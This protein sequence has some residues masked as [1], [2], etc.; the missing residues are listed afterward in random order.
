[1][2][3]NASDDAYDISRLAYSMTGSVPDYKFKVKESANYDVT[4]DLGSMT[5]SVVKSDYQQKPVHHGAVADR[6]RPRFRP[7]AYIAR[8]EG[9]LALQLHAH[10]GLGRLSRDSR[11]DVFGD[12]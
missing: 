9:W 1:M 10:V 6:C 2:Y 4:C 12:G 5:V 11:G 3:C 8:S 7:L